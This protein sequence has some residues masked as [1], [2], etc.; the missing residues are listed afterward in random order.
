M[1]RA[2]RALRRRPRAPGVRGDR[3]GRA[4]ADGRGTVHPQDAHGPR[5][6]RRRER[7]GWP[8]SGSA[9]TR[10]WTRSRSTTKSPCR[11]GAWAFRLDRRRR[12]RG[13]SG[14]CARTAGWTSTRSPMEPQ[15][16]VDYEVA[17]HYTSTWPRSPFVTKVIAQRSGIDERWMLIEDELRVERPEGRTVDGRHRPR[18]ADDPG[19]TVRSGLPGGHAVRPRL[20]QVVRFSRCRRSRKPSTRSPRTR[21]SPASCVST[22]AEGIE[23]A[24]A[25][26]LADRA[27][28]IP[29]TVDTR[30][31]IASG[32]KGLT[33][34][35][36]DE[37][38]RRGSAGAD[39]HGS[40]GAR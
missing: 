4:R 29:N 15:L 19:R 16:P 24:K 26:G 38:G 35:T 9:A 22:A 11:Q 28:A 5:R 25:Y 6:R 20:T 13:S 8:T 34:L 32:M 18:A 14:G 23:L 33:A 27:H 36:V 30:F 1:L 40:V 17:N 31:A 37:P 12:R 7:G 3:S 10:C 2:E 21:A 39:D